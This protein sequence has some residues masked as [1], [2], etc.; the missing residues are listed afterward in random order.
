MDRDATK[1]AMANTG[2]MRKVG[3]F[4]FKFMRCLYASFI[5]YFLPYMILF[6]PYLVL[7]GYIKVG[8]DPLIN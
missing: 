1:V 3:R 6:L 5:F 4:I 7:P 8:Y 2:K